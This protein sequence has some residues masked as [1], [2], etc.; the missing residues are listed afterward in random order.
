[1]D[2]RLKILQHEMVSAMDGLSAEQLRWSPEGKWCIA[3]VLEHL[4]LSYTGT[5]K[6]FERVAQAGKPLATSSTLKKR[7][8][9]LIVLGLGYMPSG[10][11]APPVTRPRGISTDIVLAEI[12]P[13]IAEMDDTIT[14]CEGSFGRGKL[15]DHPVLGPLSGAQWRKFHLVHGRHHLK[16]IQRLRQMGNASKLRREG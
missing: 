11:Q 6:G 7:L 8:Q 10:R 2:R 1:M 14:R 3:E 9:T 12:G 13:K 4:Y 16:Q 15:L 5:V